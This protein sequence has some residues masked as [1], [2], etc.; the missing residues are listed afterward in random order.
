MYLL[1]LLYILHSLNAKCTGQFSVIDNDT[2]SVSFYY[3][4]ICLDIKYIWPYFLAQ[5]LNAN[6]SQA[7]PHWALDGF[8]LVDDRGPALN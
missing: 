3:W 8:F 7:Y 5:L 6:V 4:K 2:N 1:Y